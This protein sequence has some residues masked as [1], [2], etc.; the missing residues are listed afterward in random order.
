M[1]VACEL[2]GYETNE[3]EHLQLLIDAGYGPGKIQD[4]DISNKE[5]LDRKHK[6]IRP[7]LSIENLSPNVRVFQGTE[8][9]CSCGCVGMIRGSL[10]MYIEKH[11]PEGVRPIN[12]I[13]GEPIE[14]VPD[15]LDPEITLV[16]GDCAKKYKDRG[17]FVPGCCPRP[18][19]IGIVLV[20]ILGPFDVDAKISDAIKAYMEHY[21][22]RFG[23]IMKGN[24]IQPIENHVYTHAYTK[25][26][27][28]CYETEAEDCGK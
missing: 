16:L 7:D 25:R 20:R 2:A 10:D 14:N 19:D 21:L 4:I 27:C 6:F 3:I 9:H 17:V 28:P 13:L 11:G 18:L 26:T 8:K 24:K 15:D 23:Q 5:L 12:I 1:L 22:W